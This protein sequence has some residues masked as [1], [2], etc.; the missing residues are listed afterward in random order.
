MEDEATRAPSPHTN[1]PSRGSGS[2]LGRIDP[3]IVE[4]ALRILVLTCLWG[5]LR[6]LS[7][8]LPSVGS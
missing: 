8:A 5:L 6:I 1:E 2:P 7:Q 3:R 4:V